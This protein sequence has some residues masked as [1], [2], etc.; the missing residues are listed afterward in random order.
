MSGKSYSVVIRSLGKEGGAF[1]RLLQSLNSQTLP[2]DKIII[3]LPNGIEQ[4]IPTIG[5]EEY[6]RVKKGMFAQRIMEYDE[7]S[8][9]LLLMLDDDVEFPQDGAEKLIGSLYSENL[10]CLGVDTFAN[11]KLPF[12]TKLRIAVVNWVWPMW[13]D[14]WAVRIRKSGAFSY[15]NKPRRK[16]YLSQSCPGNILLWKKNVYDSVRLNDESWLD[17]FPFAYGDDMVETYKV[18]LNGYRLGMLFDDGFKHLDARQ[19]SNELRKDSKNLSVKSAIMFIIWWRTIYRTSNSILSKLLIALSFSAKMISTGTILFV[20]GLFKLKF[21]QFSA[22]YS[23]LLRGYR[24][25][26][27][28]EF[29]RLYPYK[30]RN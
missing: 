4:P 27:R 21:G 30:F 25:I 19:A 13:S 15:N 8:S 7:V 6:K 17:E 2:P 10:D 11:Y 26:S 22:L 16:V 28:P 5:I 9:E 24:Q 20:Y 23:G 29:K 12:V 18:Y 1:K 14:R 3:Y